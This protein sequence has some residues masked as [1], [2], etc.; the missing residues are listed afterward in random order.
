MTPAQAAALLV[1]PS[2]VTN[3]WQMFAGPALRPVAL[4]LW[5]V[6]LGIVI[7]TWAGAVLLVIDTTG[8]AAAA[9]GVVLMLYAAFGLS[10]MKISVPPRFEPWV[11]PPVGVATGLVSAATSVFVLPALPY[12][13]G[14]GLDKEELVQTLGL[15][16]T[17]ST[18]ALA[19]VLA[20]NGLF[21][22]SLAGPT[23]FALAVTLVGMLLGQTVRRRV[24][25]ER[26]RL[27]F[28]IGLLG[29]GAHLALRYVLG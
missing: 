29:L 4:R 20:R 21:D 17:V 3:V 25:A 27:W 15:S 26:F 2:L 19:T 11:G 13:Q 24:S 18:V 9:L 10:G 6:M 8:R 28:F 1:L 14:I 23:M 7:G 5:P 16:F 22:L 12:Y